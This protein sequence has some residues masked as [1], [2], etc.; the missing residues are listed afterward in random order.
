MVYILLAG[1]ARVLKTKSKCIREMVCVKTQDY[2]R[3]PNN[4]LMCVS[5]SVV[6]FE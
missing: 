4:Q 2:P 1:C 3:L 6:L 5:S